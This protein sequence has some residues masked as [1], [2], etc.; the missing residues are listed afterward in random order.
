FSLDGFDELDC[1][2]SR[3]LAVFRVDELESA[4][5][6]TVL[7]SDAANSRDRTDENRIDQPQLRGLDRASQ[8]DIVARVRDSDL[9]LLLLLSS[10][11]QAAVLLPSAGFRTVG[12]A[13][14]APDA[15]SEGT[16]ADRKAI[17][18]M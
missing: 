14:H 2:G 4:N 13:S 18:P 5:V 1:L 7:F 17:C 9:D 8:R 15:L 3:D 12:H 6:E 16:D 11:D 10:G